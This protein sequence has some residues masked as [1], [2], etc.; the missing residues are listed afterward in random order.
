V[1]F[2]HSYSALIVGIIA[3]LLLDVINHCYFNWYRSEGSV[4]QLLSFVPSV[5][6]LLNVCSLL[7][8]NF[9]PLLPITLTTIVFSTFAYVLHLIFALMSNLTPAFIL[10][11]ILH[12][13]ASTLLLLALSDAL[14][15]AAT[16]PLW[17][18]YVHALETRRPGTPAPSHPPLVSVL[19]TD[20]RLS[21]LLTGVVVAV[22][23]V[24]NWGP[25]LAADL[26]QHIHDNRVDRYKRSE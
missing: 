26:R 9:R 24:P 25:K 7:F 16:Q 18:K 20:S 6:A 4:Y 3:L 2:T 8:L 17:V 13:V 10:P 22:E 11:P 21:T 15:L 19:A 14:S 1:D 23:M 5:L 12:A